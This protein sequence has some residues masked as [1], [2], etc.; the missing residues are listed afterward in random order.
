MKFIKK[1]VVFSLI[2]SFY[3]NLFSD[4]AALQLQLHDAILKNDF[5]GVQKAL[6]TRAKV[7][8]ADSANK[9]PY[10]YALENLYKYKSKYKVFSKKHLESIIL[11]FTTVY[12][13]ASEKEV[14]KKIIADKSF[15]PIPATM[16]ASWLLAYFFSLLSKDA[17]AI[18]SALKIVDLIRHQKEFVLDN[19]SKEFIKA[20]L[21]NLDK[22]I[23]LLKHSLL[24]QAFSSELM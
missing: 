18:N 19:K 7:D 15:E 17:K 23:G 3:S 6:K 4:Q 10:F 1:I 9:F 21:P 5:E 22:L 13:V 14:L 24:R 12:L 2:F 8:V 11:G 16:M 20:N